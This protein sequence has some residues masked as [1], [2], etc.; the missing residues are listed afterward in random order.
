MLSNISQRSSNTDK[1]SD[2]MNNPVDGHPASIKYMQNKDI[3]A[4]I[5]GIIQVLVNKRYTMEV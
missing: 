5:N 3:E 1:A 2:N 4:T